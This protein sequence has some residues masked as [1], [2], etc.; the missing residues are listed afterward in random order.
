MYGYLRARLLDANDAEDACQEVFLR[1]YSALDRFD[2]D[3]GHGLRPWLLGI[4]RNVLRETV[5][6]RVR[7]RE[8][9]WTELCIE[10]ETMIGGSEGMYDDVMHLL[11]KCLDSLSDAAGDALKWHY[12]G[13]M[14]L[15]EIADR[16]ERTLGAVKVLMVRARRAL[17]RCIST[18]SAM[19]KHAQ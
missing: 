11:P 9:A 18:K 2:P 10:L 17:K 3:A 7:R 5:R 14:K 4:A 13:G 1:A 12:M 19:E 6:K 8:T 16:M 15:Q